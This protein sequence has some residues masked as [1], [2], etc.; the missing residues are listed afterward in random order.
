MEDRTEEGGVKL[1][2]IDP[3]SKT[4]FL[5]WGHHGEHFCCEHTVWFNEENPDES[6]VT[7]SCDCGVDIDTDMNGEY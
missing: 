1:A 6:W 3:D 5:E 4:C 7:H 2:P